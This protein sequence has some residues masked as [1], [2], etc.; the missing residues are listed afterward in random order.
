MMYYIININEQNFINNFSGKLWLDGSYAFYL[1]KV[2]VL[3]GGNSFIEI[4]PHATFTHF[5][6]TI[7]C[8]YLLRERLCGSR[9]FHPSLPFGT[10]RASTFSS[11]CGDNVP[12]TGQR[13]LVSTYSSLR[14]RETLA[15]DVWP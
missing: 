15:R 11:G 12:G 1:N 14:D 13:R 7:Q 6:A 5:R 4:Y 10:F 9:I 2:K 8:A 3:G